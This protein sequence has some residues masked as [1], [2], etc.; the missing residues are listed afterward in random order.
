M[1]PFME[2]ALAAVQTLLES[3]QNT[4][5]CLIMAEIADEGQWGEAVRTYS[6]P[7]R[8]LG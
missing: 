1:T 2:Q 4:I 5:A 7:F 3:D 6:K 8:T